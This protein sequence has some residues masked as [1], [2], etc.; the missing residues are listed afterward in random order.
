MS[1]LRKAADR[2]LSKPTDFA[3]AEL[4]AL[5]EVFGYELKTAGGSGRKFIHAGTR[6]T[7]FIHEPHPAKVLK[8]YQV[9][10]AIRFLKQ[11]GHIS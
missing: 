9:R 6:A 3:W 10:D 5:M 11:E 8:A 4:I 1:K 2:L 7:L